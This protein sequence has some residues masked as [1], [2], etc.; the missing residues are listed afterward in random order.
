MKALVKTAP[1]VGNIEVRE[2]PEPTPGASDLIIEVKAGAICGT[3]I[4]IHDDEY[5]NRPPVILGHEMSGVVV[6][7]GAGVTRFKVGDRVTSETFKH[8]CGS[9]R[10]CRQG[11]IGL[12]TARLSMGVHVDGSFARYVSQRE[13]SV[14]RLPDNVDFD[15]GSMSEP[16]A[17]AV[18]AVYERARVS[19]G[20]IVLVS[21]PGPVGLLCLQ[22]AKS[23]GATVV[24]CGSE[25]DDH[26]LALGKELGADA[27]INVSKDSFDVVG[28]LSDGLGVD[29]ALECGGTHASL[30]QC[31]RLSRS[32]AQVVVVGL[33]GDDV[34]VDLDSAVIKELTLLPSFTYRHATWAR[35]LDLLACGSIQTAPLVSGHFPL[36]EWEPAFETVRART[37]NKYLLTPVE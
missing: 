36:T 7:V 3:D 2:V 21:G 9:C 13:E 5:P 34:S 18:R 31:V 30:E 11:L 32:G 25:G 8:T 19:A 26:R 35:A 14:H 23:L 16:T 27:V 17:V 29:V 10:F 37:G 20:D 15:A 33:F 24:L 28:D 1:G 12:C 22:A 4:H 6:E